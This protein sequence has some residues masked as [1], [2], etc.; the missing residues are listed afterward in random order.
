MVL[1]HKLKQMEELDIEH[2]MNNEEDM[3]PS[4]SGQQ[5]VCSISSSRLRGLLSAL[6][7]L[8]RRG[9]MH[10]RRFPKQQ[11]APD[12]PFHPRAD[13]LLALKLAAW[14]SVALVMKVQ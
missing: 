11:S 2:L 10:L 9:T 8:E 5:E 12:L 4:Q 7:L 14:P 13:L 6:S 3:I 1:V